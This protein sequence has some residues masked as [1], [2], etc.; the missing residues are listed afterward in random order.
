MGPRRSF[1]FVVLV[2]AACVGSLRANDTEVRLRIQDE[3]VPPG[4]VV[5]MK[6][7]RYEVTP[8]SGGRPSFQFDA[9]LFEDFV[10]FGMFAPTGELAGAAVVD[11]N[12]AAISYV[13]TRTAPGD[14]PLL[15]VALRA[16]ADAVRGS[17]TFFSLERSST[18]TMDGTTLATRVEP[19]EITVGG[20]LAVSSVV[21]GQGVFPRGTVVS[22]RG[23]GFNRQTRL[24]VENLE[25]ET[26]R[27][28]S[29][30]EMQF[31]LA[32]T[33]DLTGKRLR[34]DNRDGSRVYY[35]SY[36]RGIAD[37]VSRR[38]LLAA[39][40]PLFSGRTRTA[41]AF[42]VLPAMTSTQYAAVALLNPGLTNATVTVGLYSPAAALIDTSTVLLQS[43]HRLALELSEL[44][45]G[46]PPP[47]DASLRVMS[48][49]P[50]HVSRLLCD[51][52]A[53]TVSPALPADAIR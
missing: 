16:R 1:W 38:P 24:R 18:W 45:D 41:A 46:V 44:F 10:G 7:D 15:T 52:G 19:G 5:Q 8:I 25:I 50:I 14:L 20:S 3:T 11:H 17:S 42:G 31:T 4:G 51:E 23:M 53:W 22:V 48:S 39:T 9:S 36:T 34:L 27:Y 6:A 28:V 49:R 12:R 35:N 37:V 43:G 21:P 40:V 47:H 26:V 2:L 30:T 29:S 32:A 13:T 33:G